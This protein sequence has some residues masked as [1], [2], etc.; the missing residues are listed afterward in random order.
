[1]T[2]VLFVNPA[3]LDA[4]FTDEDAGMVPIGVYY[5]G[6]LLSENGFDVRILNLARLGPARSNAGLNEFKARVKQLAPEI[7]GFTVTHPSRHQALACARTAKQINPDVIVVFGGPAPTFMAEFLM[8]ICPDIDFIVKGEGELACLELVRAVK[9]GTL[10][11]KA[12]TIPGL[13][14]RR[15]NAVE[16]SGPARLIEDLDQLPHPARH[17]TYQHLSMSRG[18]PGK[19]TFCGSPEF[20][21]K[22]GVRF[23]SAQWFAHEIHLLFQKGVTHFFISDDTFTMDRQQVIELCRILISLHIPITWNAISRVDHVDG[24][25][26]SWMRRAGCIQISFGVESGDEKIRRTLGKPVSKQA[27]VNAFALTR[28]A[29]MMPRAYFI[30]GSPG[31]TRETIQQSIN[32]IREIKPLSAV[33]YML[34]TFPG[35]RLYRYARQTGKVTDEVW[36]QEIEDLPWFELDDNLDFKTVQSFG[37]GLRHAFYSGLPGFALSVQP[38]EDPDLAPLHADFLSRLA[39]TFSHGDYADDPRLQDPDG[40]AIGLFEKALEY[41]P[42]PRAFLGLGMIFQRQKKFN[43]A[44]DR[45]EQGLNRYENDKD[46]HVCMGVSLMNLGKFDKALPHFLRFKTDAAMARYID[47]CQNKLSG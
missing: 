3:C 9:T 5:L 35:T 17:F 39:L 2:D 27:I 23:H 42:H 10:N 22:S 12:G 30:Y 21:G 18:C 46:L 25:V 13:V 15:G 11:E 24:D 45:L 32:L 19:C 33:F 6:G 36:N 47:I 38:D 37:D 4:R 20:W 7:I 40:T 8:D 16:S 43:H 44:V 28:A 41:A 14:F 34:V 31:E 26:L 29:G 1:M